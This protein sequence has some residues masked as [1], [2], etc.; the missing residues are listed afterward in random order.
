MAK[1]PK[2]TAKPF[3]LEKNSNIYVPKPATK[4]KRGKR[5]SCVHIC[6]Y[7]LTY[8]VDKWGVRIIPHNAKCPYAQADKNAEDIVCMGDFECINGQIVCYRKQFALTNI[9]CGAR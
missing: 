9:Y 6:K 4:T 3:A 1:S 8:P 5:C 7:F 2:V